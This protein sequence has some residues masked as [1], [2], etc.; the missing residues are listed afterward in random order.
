MNSINLINPYQLLGVTSKSTLRELTKSYYQ[1]SLLCHPDRG[2]NQQDMIVVTQAYQYIK[3]QLDNCKHQTTYEQLEQDFQEFCQSQEEIIPPFREI[4]EQTEECKRLQA[5]NCEFIKQRNK[6]LQQPLSLSQRLNNPFTE[7]YG[8][9]MDPSEY[10]NHQ[11]TS[12]LSEK[13]TYE[14]TE[15]D[16]P[17][18]SFGTKLIVYQE[19]VANPYDYGTNFRLDVKSI[20]DFSIQQST[21]S[22]KDYQQAHQQETFPKSLF[23]QLETRPQTV[24]ELEA[25]RTQFTDLYYHQ[26]S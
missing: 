9:L 4:W 16:P 10:R 21:M 25:Q 11:P 5:F 26:S 24:E 17:K 22:G 12:I 2:G 8:T 20:N 14:T 15:S 3:R 1:L 23:L 18:H 7:G 13:T 19:P 6:E